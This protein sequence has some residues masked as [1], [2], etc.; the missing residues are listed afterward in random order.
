MLNESF[1]EPD[2]LKVTLESFVNEWNILLA[3]PFRW[4]YDGQGLHDKA[5]KRFTTMLNNSPDQ[6]D[7]RTLT[8][9]IMLMTNLLNDYFSQVSEETWHQLFASLSSQSVTIA[10]LIQQEQGPQ[11]KIKAQNAVANLNAALRKYS[12]SPVVELAA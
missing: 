11:R 10:T 1:S 2:D 6:I 3:H 7:L 5:V 9:L 4:N 12:L 8:K